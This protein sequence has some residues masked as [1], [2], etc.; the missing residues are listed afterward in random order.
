MFTN[1]SYSMKRLITFAFVFLFSLPIFAQLVHVKG[2]KG[3]FSEF[4]YQKNGYSVGLGFYKIQ[5]KK[6][7]WKT[8]AEFHSTK[9]ESTTTNHYN[10]FGE[11]CFNFLSFKQ[12]VFFNISGGVA[13]GFE[14]LKDNVFSGSKSSPVLAESVGLNIEWCPIE[15]LTTAINFRQRFTQFNRN[16]NAYFMIGLSVQYNFN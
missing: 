4:N 16:G 13:F 8:S 1:N 11:S 2:V 5:T 9:Q 14:Q 10:V 15:K 6:F 3:L 7:I 12:Q